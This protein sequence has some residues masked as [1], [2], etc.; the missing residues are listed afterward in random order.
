[1]TNKHK[2]TINKSKTPHKNTRTPQPREEPTPVGKKKDQKANEKKDN[3]RATKI[4]PNTE[5]QLHTRIS[6]YG[7]N[8]KL[9]VSP[10]QKK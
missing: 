4:R 2:T 1:V 3:K 5:T 10:I 9:N 6:T 8:T 7:F